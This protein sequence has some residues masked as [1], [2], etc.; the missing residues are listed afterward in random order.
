M[1]DS[2]FWLICKTSN[3]TEKE[4]LKTVTPL[5]AVMGITG[6]IVIMIAARL[7]PLI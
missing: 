7:L 2:G 1:N 5:L 3:L 6:I 4:A